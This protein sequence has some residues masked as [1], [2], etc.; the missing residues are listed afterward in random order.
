MALNSKTYDLHVIFNTCTSEFFLISCFISV[1]FLTIYYFTTTNIRTLR[2][3][4]ILFAGVRCL[5]A[6][7]ERDSH[8][9]KP[10]LE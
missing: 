2:G 10:L 6:A 3:L 7:G 1:N 5:L 9:E 8:S 4:I